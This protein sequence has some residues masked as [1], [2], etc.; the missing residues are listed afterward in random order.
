M[1]PTCVCPSLD[2]SYF[3]S[4]LGSP[5]GYLAIFQIPVPLEKPIE[6]LS[7]EDGLL[8]VN[9]YEISR[10]MLDE[11]GR[12]QALT[13][14]VQANLLKAET[15]ED[16]A[17]LIDGFLISLQE[18]RQTVTDILMTRS[19]RLDQHTQQMEAFYSQLS[20]SVTTAR[21]SVA[22]ASNDRQ[23]Q[24]MAFEQTRRIGLQHLIEHQNIEGHVEDSLRLRQRARRFLGRTRLLFEYLSLPQPGEGG[25]LRQALAMVLSRSG[26]AWHIKDGL[27]KFT[28]HPK[29]LLGTTFTAT[30]LGALLYPGD[31]YSYVRPV[32]DFGAILMESL[33]GRLMDLYELVKAS[34]LSNGL[35]F[36]QQMWEAFVPEG[37]FYRFVIANSFLILGPLLFFALIHSTV[38]AVYL[39]SGLRQGGLP[40]TRQNFIH[41]Q[42]TARQDYLIANA[43]S[44][45]DSQVRD[46]TEEETQTVMNIIKEQE[47]LQ[48]KRPIRQ[49]LEKVKAPLRRISFFQDREGVTDTRIRTLWGAVQNAFFSLQSLEQTYN[50]L[51]YFWWRDRFAVA[52]YIWKPSTFLGLMYYP[53]AHRTLTH[54]GFGMVAPHPLTQANGGQRPFWRQYPLIL[55]RW[56]GKGPYEAYQEFERHILPIE[57]QIMRQVRNRAL[58]QALERIKNEEMA[59]RVLQGSNVYEQVQAMDREQSRFYGLAVDQLFKRVFARV[60]APL[61]ESEACGVSIEECLQ[62]MDEHKVKVLGRLR[63]FQPS[64]EDI[65]DAITKIE[66]DGFYAEIEDQLQQPRQVSWT[67]RFQRRLNDKLLKNLDHH[68]NTATEHWLRIEAQM[69]D[70]GARQRAT[71]K[72][73]YDL[74]EKIPQLFITW[75]AVS[76]IMLNSI[77]GE[78]SGNDMMVPLTDD[79]PYFSEYLFGAGFF[80]SVVLD[81][82]AQYGRNLRLEHHLNEQGVFQNVPE[83]PN[84][85]FLS[86]FLK[87]MRDRDNTVWKNT[88]TVWRITWST[89]PAYLT[90]FTLI[91]GL[92][93]GR[94]P[95]D[96]YLIGYFLYFAFPIYGL[97]IKIQQAMEGTM[98]GYWLR[99]FPRTLRDHPIAQAHSI[100]NRNRRWSIFHLFFTSIYSNIL[101]ATLGNIQMMGVH[102]S[103]EFARIVGF[104][105]PPTVWAV[106]FFNLIRESVG[107]VPVF[108]KALDA[109]QRFLTNNYDGWDISRDGE[110]PEGINPWKARK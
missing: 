52:T 101:G 19:Q 4:A 55:A 85:S 74:F 64:Q 18:A 72:A 32:V 91:Y 46:F 66:D 22:Q 73:F 44:F 65:A 16:M 58:M 35:L 6:T 26:E 84:I 69:Q 50:P 21:L 9:D 98:A 93:L 36:P 31:A 81:M 79:F 41:L 90:S 1:R 60:V 61:F 88:K 3:Q 27:V 89:I 45:M 43:T 95:L 5:D 97:N 67:E 77:A 29:L 15:F 75:A 68:Q 40:F 51:T 34:V 83:D 82:L 28:D 30:F 10:Q 71:R 49:F 92:T 48:R 47:R 17:P 78:I 106:R 94:F 13:W 86:W 37:R 62:N 38:N 108:D 54:E 107:D 2:L 53:N 57:T 39:L 70:A 42:D 7:I 96:V 102:T 23:R 12:L 80:A 109:C 87:Q 25:R 99:Y 76:G 104:G 59:T 56:M 63:S 33:H 103:R 110:P 20:Q 8:K 24:D 11:L 105:H 14:N 100:Q